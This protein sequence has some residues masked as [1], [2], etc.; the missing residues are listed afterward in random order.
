M[1]NFEWAETEMYDEEGMLKLLDGD[2][3]IALDKQNDNLENGEDDTEYN[4]IT[5]I[6]NN[7]AHR[8]ILGGPQVSGLTCFMEHICD[9]NGYEYPW[10]ASE[11][12]QI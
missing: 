1:F 2:I 12:K 6:V 9:E 10:T 3:N 8:F 4:Y 5:I 7:V 11:V